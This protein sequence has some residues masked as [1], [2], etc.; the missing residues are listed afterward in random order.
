MTTSNLR[1]VTLSEKP[2]TDYDLT[3]Q[4]PSA[5]QGILAS[6]GHCFGFCALLAPKSHFFILEL[7]ETTESEYWT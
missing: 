5:L 7:V 3:L 1:G 4:S 6:L 2:T